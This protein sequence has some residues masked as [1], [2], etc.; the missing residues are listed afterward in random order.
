MHVC[1]EM[2]GSEYLYTPVEESARGADL[3]NLC[4]DVCVED[5]ETDLF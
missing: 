4:P 5:S 1:Q 2:K 3:T